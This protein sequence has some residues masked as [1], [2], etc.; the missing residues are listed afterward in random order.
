M[1]QPKI[2]LLCGGRFAFPSIQILG[3]EKYL[4]GVGIGKADEKVTTFLSAEMERNQ[5]PFRSFDNKSDVE[6]LRSWID[7]LKPDYIFSICFPFRVP[8][9]ALAY[10]KNK[11]FNF[12]TG[13]LPAYRGPM[14]IFEVL[15]YGE[16]ETAVCVHHMEADFDEGPIVLSEQISIRKDDTFGSLATKL[17]EHT[18][19]IAL[20]MAQMLEYGSFVPSTDQDE[21]NA[22]YFEFPESEDTTIN[23][24]RMPAEEISNLVRACNPWNNGADAMI[25]GKPV[26]IL[27]SVVSEESHTSLPGT[28]IEDEELLKIACINGHQLIIEVLSCDYGIVSAQRFLQLI[29]KQHFRQFA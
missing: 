16:T 20:N 26:K 22:R 4:C 13:P 21:S 9:E 19:Y 10:G 8:E 15:R 25:N 6:T 17:S 18:S 3:F 14:P 29:Q 12:H 11:F 5:F 24:N 2:L 28:I 27:Q 7:E 1:E 23:W